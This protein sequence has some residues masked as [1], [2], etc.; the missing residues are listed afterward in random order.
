MEE[1]GRSM[2]AG[3]DGL[4]T[5]SGEGEESE[6]PRSTAAVKKLLSPCLAGH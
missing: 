6:G 5:P 4:P 3:K 1:R 2:L